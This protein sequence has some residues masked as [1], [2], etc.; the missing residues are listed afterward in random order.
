MIYEIKGEYLEVLNEVSEYD[1]I[2]F[3]RF[4]QFEKVEKST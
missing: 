2:I 1:E 4:S 3:G